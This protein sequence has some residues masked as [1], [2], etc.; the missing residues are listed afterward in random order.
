MSGPTDVRDALRVRSAVRW[1][2]KLDELVYI[3]R[4]IPR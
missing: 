2:A 3:A 1:V 4:Y